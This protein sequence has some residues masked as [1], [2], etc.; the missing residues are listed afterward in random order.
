MHANSF[1]KKYPH[2]IDVT[3]RGICLRRH[4]IMHVRLLYRSRKLALEKTV[5]ETCAM[6]SKVISL[7]Q[8]NDEPQAEQNP[9]HSPISYWRDNR[10]RTRA[11]VC[12]SLVRSEEIQEHRAVCILL[13]PFFAH[14]LYDRY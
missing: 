2:V 1:P 7:V 6:T 3:P 13:A 14:L 4:Q 11:F 8:G 5:L 9:R 10:H 12:A